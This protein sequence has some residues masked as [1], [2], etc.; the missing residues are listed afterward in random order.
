MSQSESVP[1]SRRRLLS[2]AAG[3]AGALGFA[4]GCG[5]VAPSSQSSSGGGSKGKL[6]LTLFAFLGGDLATMP[7]AFAKEYEASHRNVQIDIY[8]QSNTVGY[9]KMLAQKKADPHR[10]LVNLG[11][12]NAETTVQGVGDRMWSKLDYSSMS[13]AKDISKQFQRPDQYGIGIGADQFGLVYNHQKLSTAPTS[14][15]DLWNPTYK[16]QLCLFQ[17]P[18]YAVFMAAKLHGGSINDME[19]GWK[20]WQDKADQIRLMVDSNPQYLNVLSSGTAPLTTYFAGTGQQWIDSGAPLKYVVPKEGAISLPVYLQSVAGSTDSQLEVAQDMIN[21]MISP[22][23]SAR[24]A[25]ASVETPANTKAVLPAKL[26]HLPAFSAH[27]R[28]HFIDVD[29]AVVGKNNAAWQ[30]RWNRDVSSHI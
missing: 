3:L 19:P 20:L 18:W 5:S 29:Y 10:P 21:E 30:Q 24:W 23:W 6:K 17:N 9:A 28:E 1:L 11:F 4:A 2:G 14:W 26:A 16:G 25:D 7:K 12:F 13:N 15:A 8:E 27:T 22:K